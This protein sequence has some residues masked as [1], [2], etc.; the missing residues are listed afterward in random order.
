MRKAGCFSVA[1]SSQNQNQQGAIV[2]LF[3]WVGSTPR[4]LGKYADA[5]LETDR[6]SCVYHTTAASLD[7][8]VRLSNLRVLAKSAL[9][10]ITTRHPRGTPVVIMSMS[11][12][13]AFVYRAMLEMLAEDATSVNIVGTIFDSAPA[14][15]SFQSA[16][17]AVSEGAKNAFIRN[18]IYWAARLFF[19]LVFPLISGGF[20]YPQRFWRACIADPLACPSLYIYSSS[21]ELTDANQLDGLVVARRERHPAGEAG[22]RVLRLT[23]SPHV[24]HL[25]KHPGLYK[26][27]LSHFLHDITVQKQ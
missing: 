10:L 15:L 25:A 22:V 7:V 19:P 3:G 2:L 11:N 27:A 16:A 18:L 17:R 21:D 26:Q 14:Y 8:F 20:D 12:G 4:L 1:E 5:L 6:V 9:D 24:S 23:N 13:G